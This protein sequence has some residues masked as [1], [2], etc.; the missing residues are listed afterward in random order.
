MKTIN[1]RGEDFKMKITITLPHDFNYL[2]ESKKIKILNEEI[3][4]IGEKPSII[5]TKW[6]NFAQE[7]SEKKLLSGVGNFVLQQSQNLRKDFSFKND[8]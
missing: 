2:P 7:I 6:V 4:N 8:G 1:K 3:R 5:K